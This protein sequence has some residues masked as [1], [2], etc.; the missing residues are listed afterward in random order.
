MYA[1]GCVLRAA[2]SA[3]QR[4]ATR[5]NYSVHVNELPRRRANHLH[6]FR[7]GGILM[8]DV[9]YMRF[10]RRC[11]NSQPFLGTLSGHP[12]AVKCSGIRLL[13]PELAVR[14]PAF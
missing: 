4:L 3:E 10:V 8:P 5:S 2:E 13:N 7:R 6:Q 1:Q 9:G 14:A 12:R 11:R